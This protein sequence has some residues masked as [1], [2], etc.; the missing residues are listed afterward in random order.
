MITY[1]KRIIHQII[2]K[3]NIV[4]LEKRPT[5]DLIDLINLTNDGKEIKRILKNEKCT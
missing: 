3:T 4:S 5:T 2:D 1:L